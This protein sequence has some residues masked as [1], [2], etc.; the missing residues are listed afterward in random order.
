MLQ[1]LKEAIIETDEASRPENV[2]FLVESEA[3]LQQ[4]E[5]ALIAEDSVSQHYDEPSPQTDTQEQK[6]LTQHE[7][8]ASID[9][10]LT[11]PSK[12]LKFHES[13]SIETKERAAVTPQLTTIEN[14]QRHDVEKSQHELLQPTEIQALGKRKYSKTP[15]QTTWQPA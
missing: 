12:A 10:P 6:A 2:I 1:Q 7:E 11:V 3:S 13:T 14:Q 5:H 15:V 9:I 8:S 4:L